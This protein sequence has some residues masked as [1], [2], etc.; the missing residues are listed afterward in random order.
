MEKGRW[1]N[2]VGKFL[3]NSVD[4]VHQCKFRNLLLLKCSQQYSN[5]MKHLVF[6]LPIKIL[7][8]LI[9][10]ISFI[11]FKRVKSVNRVFRLENYQNSIELIT[12]L[13]S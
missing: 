10:T 6:I 1:E 5:E 11:K 8:S 9:I 2:F 12:K 7:K 4:R 13:L 3:R